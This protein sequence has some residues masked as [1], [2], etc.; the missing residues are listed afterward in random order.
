[1]KLTRPQQRVMEYLRG[2]HRARRMYGEVVYVNGGKVGTTATMEALV[3]RGLIELSGVDEWKV[4]E[5]GK[6]AA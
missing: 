3:K 2:G 1:M 6:I 4:T 5:K